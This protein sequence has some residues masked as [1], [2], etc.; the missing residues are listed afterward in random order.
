MGIE[1]GTFGV[2][3]GLAGLRMRA[4][5]LGVEEARLQLAGRVAEIAVVGGIDVQAI[6]KRGRIEA[7][8]D[9]LPGDLRHPGRPV[10]VAKEGQK[11]TSSRPA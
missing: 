8:D 5:L 11:A 10:F 7:G 4:R 1:R 9:L 3:P 2:H 6:P